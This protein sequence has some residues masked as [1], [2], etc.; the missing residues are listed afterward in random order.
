MPQPVEVAE[1]SWEAQRITQPS[2]V[3]HV[4]VASVHRLLLLDVYVLKTAVQQPLL[5]LRFAKPSSCS[6]VYN[7]ATRPP[8][9]LYVITNLLVQL[10]V[11]TFLYNCMQ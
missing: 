8:V 6:D 11:L 9:S 5:I 2:S 3:L 7:N 10:R 4:D 1:C